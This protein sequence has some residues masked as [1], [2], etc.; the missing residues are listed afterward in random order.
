V[1]R[2][3][4]DDKLQS[5]PMFS[6]L[7]KRELRSV[8][9]LMTQIEVAEGRELM[10]EGEPGREFMIIVEGEATVRK[11]GRKVATLG[12]G[13]FVGELS[14]LSGQPRNATVEAAS[15]MTVEAL[16]RREFMSLLDESPKLAKKILLGAIVRLQSVGTGPTD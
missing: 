15:P 5:I 1:A 10:T 6:G 13:D 8:S 3:E 16:N 7:S 2:T 11:K 9:R 4:I 12:A 14:V